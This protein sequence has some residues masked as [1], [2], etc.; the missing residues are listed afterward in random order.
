MLPRAVADELKLRYPLL[1]TLPATLFER[2]VAEA[3]YAVVPR[4]T[5]LFDERQGCAAFPLVL[6]GVVRVSKAAASG[7]ELQLYR[8]SPGESCILTSGCLLGG[9]PYA[10]RGVAESETRL[11]TLPP[12]TFVRLIDE[13]P[14]FRQHVFGLF[15]ERIAELM[16]L[17]EEIAFRRLDERLAALLVDRGPQVRATHQAL[18]DDLGSVREMVTRLLRAFAEQ[19]WVRLAREQIEVMDAAALKRLA[20][21]RPTV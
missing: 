4:G 15:S 11:V 1:E 21:N 17:V 19:G 13:H 2:I 5:V 12:A 16:Q 14:P 7:R 8:V 9:Q 20:G 10:A 3:G 6:E 18:A